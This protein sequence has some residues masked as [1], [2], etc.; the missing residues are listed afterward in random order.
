MQR[1]SSGLMG[2]SFG[3]LPERENMPDRH[4]CI[5]KDEDNG[6]CGLGDTKS[7]RTHKKR[8]VEK[9]F[10]LHRSSGRLSLFPRRR[11]KRRHLAFPEWV[12]ERR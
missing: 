1:Q 8:D 5:H 12:P 6:H 9:M 4:A 10:R 2:S 3:L 7:T 11:V